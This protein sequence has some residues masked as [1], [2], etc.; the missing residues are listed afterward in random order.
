MFFVLNVLLNKLRKETQTYTVQNSK[1]LGVKN[2]IIAVFLTLVALFG[3]F[4]TTHV[5]SAMPFYDLRPQKLVL[6]SSFYTTYSNSNEERKSN[7]ALAVKSLNKTFIDVNGEF[8]FNKTVGERTEKRGYKVSKIIVNGEFVDGVGGGVCQVSTTL[9]NAVLTA[10]LKITEYHP[11]SLP[12]SYVAPSFDAMVNSSW[13]DLRFINDTHNP[14]YIL[15]SADGERIKIEIWGEPL[16]VK[17]E[18]KSIVT[19]EIEAPKEQVLYDDNGEYP[20]LY[21]GERLVLKYSKNGIKS[22]GY[23]VCVKAGRVISQRKIR[24]DKYGAQ[25]GKVIIGKAVKKEPLDDDMININE[26]EQSLKHS[27]AVYVKS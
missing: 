17:Y 8:S 21:E 19:G 13:A 27:D 26:W 5:V 25:Q 4:N 7:I 9:Y 6:R 22:E 15:A 10:G 16:N 2:F 1:K 24:T 11:H 14:V 18:R 23:L 12:V 3:C 20:E